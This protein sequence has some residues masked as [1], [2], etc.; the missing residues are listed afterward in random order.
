MK[1]RELITLFGRA[2]FGAAAWSLTAH[3]QQPERTRR[4]GVLMFL[5]EDDPESKPRIAAFIEGLRQLGWIV[6]RNIQLENRWGG[7]DAVR[8]RRYAAELEQIPFD[9]IH[10]L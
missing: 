6:G 4:I 3:A 1:R 2:A 8:S 10:S 9:F 7:A 5:A